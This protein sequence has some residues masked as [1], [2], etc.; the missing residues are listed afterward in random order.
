M[1]RTDRQRLKLAAEE[2]RRQALARMLAGLAPDPD[3]VQLAPEDTPGTPEYQ[4][5]VE[6]I[7]QRRLFGDDDDER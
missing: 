2:K 4:A 1:A 6:R 3:G 5:L 7:G